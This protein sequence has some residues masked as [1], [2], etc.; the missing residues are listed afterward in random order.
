MKNSIKILLGV[1]V[2]LV[3]IGG[4][5]MALNLMND[6]SKVP[7]DKNSSSDNGTDDVKNATLSDNKT[8]SSYND[9]DIVKEEIKFNAQNGEGYYREVTYRDGGFRQFDV[10]TGELIGSSYASDQDKLPSMEWL[11]MILKDLL[12]HFDIEESFPDYLLE[13][14]FNEVF[15]DGDLS[16][17]DNNYKIVVKTRQ[18]VIHQMF[19]KPAEDYPVIIMSEL[20]NGSLNGMKFGQ[21]E[22]DVSYISEL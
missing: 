19:L 14:S 6:D 18:D 5:V 21:S 4:A 10:E 13:Q 8:N 9:S 3:V 2:A 7:E 12:E 16:K 17:S 11:K 22:D 20:P 1:I 15:L